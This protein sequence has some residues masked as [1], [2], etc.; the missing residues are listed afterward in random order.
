MW[1]KSGLGVR[2]TNVMFYRAWLQ[3]DKKAQLQIQAEA[4]EVQVIDAFYD[5]KQQTPVRFND[6]YIFDGEHS[7]FIRFSAPQKERIT[8]DD[9]I[10]IGVLPIDDYWPP[11]T[12]D[13]GWKS[14]FEQL[15]KEVPELARSLDE[16]IRIL[17]T[18]GSKFKK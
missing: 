6:A 11:I 9:W 13:S 10:G 17:E 14:A 16:K 1:E 5:V 2:G 8:E 12:L 18:P 3:D 4:D 15:K 7:E